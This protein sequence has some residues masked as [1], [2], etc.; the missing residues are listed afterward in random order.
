M[1]LHIIKKTYKKGQVELKVNLYEHEKRYITERVE[2]QSEWKGKKVLP[3]Q[4]TKPH[5]TQR[6]IIEHITE[7]SKLRKN[8]SEPELKPDTTGIQILLK[9]TLTSSEAPTI[10]PSTWGISLQA[11][12]S[13]S[14]K[15]ACLDSV[16]RFTRAE[17]VTESI[18]LLEGTEVRYKKKVRG[19]CNMGS[20]AYW[21]TY[22]QRTYD[23]SLCI[24]VSEGSSI[25]DN[26]DKC[27]WGNL[28]NSRMNNMCSYKIIPVPIYAPML[29]LT[30][31]ITSSIT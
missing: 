22:S 28:I 10:L 30:W 14:W 5:W 25:V 4:E 24:C 8:L 2:A 20:E 1:S 15:L 29:T 19:V 23:C 31:I 27:K 18:R 16:P 26:S 9:A 11:R 21:C 3:K 7:Y 6:R 13:S 12:S 17:L